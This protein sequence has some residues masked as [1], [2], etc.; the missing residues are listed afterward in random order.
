MKQVIKIPSLG[1]A[2]NTEVIEICVNPGDSVGSE[3]S[4]VAVSYSHLTLPTKA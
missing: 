3:D 2:E 1:D 4:I